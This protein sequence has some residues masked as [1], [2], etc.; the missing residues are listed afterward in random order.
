LES[1]KVDNSVDVTA[2]VSNTGVLE[3]RLRRIR[4]SSLGGVYLEFSIRD[5]LIGASSSDVV[6]RWPCKADL[7]TGS[8]S[9]HRVSRAV[10]IV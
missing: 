10:A 1:F 5:V 2:Q 9:S 3:S 8:V 4:A 6:L 7:L